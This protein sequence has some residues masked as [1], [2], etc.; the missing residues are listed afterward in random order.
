MGSHLSGDALAL[1]MSCWILLMLLLVMLLITIMILIGARADADADA[2]ACWCPCWYSCLWCWYRL[3]CSYIMGDHVYAAL[4]NFHAFSYA[5]DNGAVGWCTSL[6]VCQWHW[7]ERTA[8]GM[9]CWWCRSEYS[10]EII[11]ELMIIWDEAGCI[12]PSARVKQGQRNFCLLFTNSFGLR[13]SSNLLVILAAV[14]VTSKEIDAHNCQTQLA[15][16]MLCYV[17]YFEW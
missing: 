1:V 12:G 5:A 2:D 6:P 17:L 4:T 11:L 15:H 3:W 13:E 8:F 14:M 10:R 16:A 9:S 7:C